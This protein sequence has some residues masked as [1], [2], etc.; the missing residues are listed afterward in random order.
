MLFLME[1]SI[2]SLLQSLERE[3][4]GG[5]SPQ[6]V[7]RLL[8]GLQDAGLSQTDLAVHVE[9]W[10]A[11]NEVGEDDEDFEEACQ[12]ALDIISG[13]TLLGLSWPGTWAPAP[14]AVAQG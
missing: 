9:R 3:L 7:A 6:E 4:H 12:C 5:A 1:T 11:V 10:R 13:T 2:I 8:R 14:H